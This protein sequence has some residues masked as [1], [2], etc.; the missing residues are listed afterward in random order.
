VF[1]PGLITGEIFAQFYCFRIVTIPTAICNMRHLALAGVFFRHTLPVRV[2]RPIRMM[3]RVIN[4]A[5]Q[6]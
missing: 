1:N 3:K 4:S 5:L 6:L 2:S